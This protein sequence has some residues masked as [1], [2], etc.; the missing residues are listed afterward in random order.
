MSDPTETFE[1]VK[2]IIIRFAGDSGDGMQLTGTQFTNASAVFGNDISTMPDFPAEIR[3]PAGTLAGVSGFQVNL[4]SHD[5]L[6]PGD[7]PQALVAMNP[8][9]LKASL[10]DL[11]TGGIIIVNTD[12]FTRSN[13]HKAGYDENPL[14]NE[15]LSQYRVHPVPLTSLN[16]EALVDVEGLSSKDKDRSQNFF[17]LGIV[18]WM[19]DRPMDITR[20]WL[21][22]KFAK[23]PQVIEANSK[24]M[25][26]G[27]NLGNTLEIFQQRFRI[28]PAALPPGTY[29]KVTGNEAMAMGLVTA[30]QKMGKP[31][32]YGTYPIT[33]ASDILHALAPLRN[34]DVRTFHAEDEIAAMGSIIGASFGGALAATGTSG[35][36]IALKSEAMN[37]AVML[38]LPMVIVNVQRGGPSTGLPTKVEQSD[39]FQ[40]MFGRNG[41]SPVAVLSPR[42]P[43]DCFD[44]AIEAARLAVRSMSPVII[45][46][47]GFLA[48]SSEP[49]LIPDADD[50]PE[51]PVHHP[52][53]RANGDGPFLPYK[54]DPETLARPWAIPGTP[55]L[56][57]RM[58]G[59]A[60]APDTGNVSYFPPHNEQMT[61]ER[62]EKIA[63]LADVIPEQDVYGPDSGELLVISW[64]GTFG[65]VRTAVAQAQAAGQS[66]AHAHARYLNPFPRNFR[67]LLSRY[68]RIV[69]A[70]LNAGQLAF[71]IRG[72]Y[73]LNVQS[74]NKI[75][76]QPFKIRE[77]RKK[78]EEILA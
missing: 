10:P 2:S 57:H 54:R 36:G 38:E 35:P 41:E 76:G 33:P 42:S 6:T 67:D 44:I 74:F 18:F 16:R 17:A 52:A 32:F 70:E 53:G 62:A 43:S 68:R 5:V 31:L 34:F 29:R 3:A 14:E 59:L 26:A 23:R 37:L 1:E 64:G 71:L 39:L 48:N 73:V 61:A 50:I 27:Y 55:G 51:I 46:S 78:I 15:S 25:Q 66:V 19:F 75:Q 69:V 7:A 60:K 24:A 47:D 28:R 13:L 77:V 58:G 12:A 45:L 20:S 72:R 56:E 65:A 63:R 40:A 9:A 4:S 11:E 8:A 22:K 49:W 21:E 30:A